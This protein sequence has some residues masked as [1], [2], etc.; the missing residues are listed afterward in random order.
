MKKFLKNLLA[1]LGGLVLIGFIV[2]LA[3][4]ASMMPRE[5][6]IEKSSILV[7]DLKGVILDGS[8]FLENLEKY[9]K[10]DAIKGVLIRV[11]SPGGVVGPSQEIYQEIRRVREEWNKPVVVAS[12]AVMASGAYYAAVGADKIVVNAG[13]MVGSIGVI[14]NFANLEKLYSWAKIERYALTSGPYK[15]SGADYKGMTEAEK[16]LFLQMIGEIHG[17]FKAAVAEG[18]NLSP[19]KVEA[20]ADGRV[21]TGAT[22]VK[23]KFADQVGTFEDAKR[24]IGNL[25]GLGESPELFFPPKKRPDVFEVLSEIKTPLKG[26]LPEQLLDAK[27]VGQPLYMLPGAVK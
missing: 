17:Q 25:S 2:A 12:S 8:E 1:L 26:L 10:K 20:F 13:T 5:A 4:V 9:R 3:G 22:A 11:D 27:L 6:R 24:L 14:M 15:D 21:F 18:R 7:L 16:S 19:D 23:Y